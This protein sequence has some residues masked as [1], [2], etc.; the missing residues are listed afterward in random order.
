MPP[1][2]A[3][4]PLMANQVVPASVEYCHVPV[5]LTSPVTATP[6]TAP[7]SKSVTWPAINVETR[8]PLLVAWSSLIVAKLLAPDRTGASLTLVT[9]MFEVAAAV[10][11]AVV[12]PLT[13]TST[14]VPAL[15]VVWSQ[16]QKVTLP[17]VPF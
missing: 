15:P 3:R 2:R 11:K 16:A 5:L 1:A 8:S 12:P 9:V 14:L 6:L 10:L 13:E 17:V 7:L 4:Q